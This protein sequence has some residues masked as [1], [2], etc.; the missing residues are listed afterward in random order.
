MK[1]GS[2]FLL[3][4][5]AV[6][7]IS[8]ASGPADMISRLKLPNEEP[9]EPFERA[10][11]NI[12]MDTPL[13]QKYFEGGAVV[14][15]GPG[16]K[17]AENIQL[18]GECLIEGKEYKVS[19][20]LVSAVLAGKNIFCIPFSLENPA[21]GRT[22]ADE[23]FWS[24]AEDEAGVLLSFDDDHWHTWYRYFDTLAG[25]GAKVTFFV[26][27]SLEKETP[28]GAEDRG[29][30]PDSDEEGIEDFCIEALSRGH[31]LGFHTINHYNLTKVSGEIFETET[32]EAAKVFSRAGIHFSAFGFPFGFSEP[33]MREA[34]APFFP[35]TRGYGVNI[36]FY[37]PE[38]IVNRYIVSKAIDNIIYPDDKKFESDIF[39]ILLAAK[40]SGNSIVPFTTHDISDTAQWGIKPGRLEYLL[41][42]AKELKLK[43]YSY[44]AINKVSK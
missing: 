7:G 41:K 17:G 26:Q 33:W 20:D 3:I 23:L 14:V 10:V 9:K 6:F 25:F 44:N 28:A 24:P 39:L 27:G 8:C 34:L 21:N 40:F 32:I 18:K 11:W 35:F 42:T 5:L 29:S 36:R 1:H 4:L 16:I 43:F 37:N 13:F 12:K 31:D 38:T 22:H 19:Y 30:P 2:V 15:A